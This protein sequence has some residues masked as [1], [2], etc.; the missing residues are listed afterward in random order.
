MTFLSPV[1]PRVPMTM[2]S[3]FDDSASMTSAGTPERTSSSTGTPFSFPCSATY[4]VAALAVSSVAFLSFTYS[5]V[6]FPPTAAARSKAFAMAALV[7]SLPSV[8]TK[9]FWNPISLTPV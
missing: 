5:A 3:N 4:E 7:Y 6:T 8:G 9:M 2:T 1:L